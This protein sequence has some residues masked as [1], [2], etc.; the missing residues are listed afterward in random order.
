MTQDEA[1]SVLKT[2]ANAFVTGEPGSGKTHTI[3]RYIRYLRSHSIEPSVTASTGIAATHVG[4]MTIHSWSGINIRKTLSRYE[5]D[6]LS[7]KEYLVKRLTAAKVLVIDEI[8]MLDADTLDTVEQVCRTLRRKAEPF[9]GLQII[10]VGDFFQLPPVARMGEPKPRFAFESR[11]WEAAR[12]FVC[13]LTEQHRQ[14]DDVFLSVLAE[15][16]RGEPSDYS[17]EH[18]ATRR[19]MPGSPVLEIQTKLYTHNADV[20]RINTEKLGRLEG[21]M[22]TFTMERHGSGTIVEKLAQTCLSPEILNL[23]EGAIVMCTKNNPEMGFVNGTLGTVMRFEKES[24]RPV[25]K[26]HDKRELTLAPMEWTIEDNGKVIAKVVQIP[27]RL[28]WA[29]TVHKSQG[30]SLDAAVIDLSNAFEYGQG[31][32]ALSRIRTLDGLHLL[33]INERALEVHPQIL[34][35]DADMRSSSK[36]VGNAFGS[37]S[38][39]EKKTMEENFIRAQGGTL[40]EVKVEKQTGV[41]RI[42]S[43]KKKTPEEQAKSDS[44]QAKLAKL[45]EKFP[46]AFMPWKKEDDEK[47]IANFDGEE[48]VPKL[49]KLMGRQ[50]GSIRARLVKHGLIE[51]DTVGAVEAEIF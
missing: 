3:N 15:L 35:K 20:D 6:A 32:V 12:P 40:E 11:A 14:E 46:N 45:R 25:I 9:G 5:L 28:A 18:L 16:R 23:K 39:V 7:E 44:Y 4:G 10:F 2:G 41:T 34:E 47:L 42:R 31:Y 24:G 48:S 22:R 33:G 49:I 43:A 1:F 29:M 27:L 21:G 50:R 51:D 13:Y 8:S 19:V 37:M 36:D 30:M 17:R 38:A 26:T